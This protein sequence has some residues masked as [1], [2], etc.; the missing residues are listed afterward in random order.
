MKK[1]LCFFCQKR[2][3]ARFIDDAD[4]GP[5]PICNECFRAGL[6]SGS[7]TQNTPESGQPV[8]PAGEP[9]SERCFGCGAE[10]EEVRERSKAAWGAGIDSAAPEVEFT[11]RFM[12]CKACGEVY[13]TNSQS[14]R[15]TV[16]VLKAT[17]AVERAGLSRL[18]TAAQAVVENAWPVE[19]RSVEH[20]PGRLLNALRDVSAQLPPETP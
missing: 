7:I 4:E 6:S 20:V 12:R 3:I 10:V 1:D 13:Y 9:E 19:A 18:R 8:V 5:V 16:E 17:V 11:D 15:H 14:M 2:P